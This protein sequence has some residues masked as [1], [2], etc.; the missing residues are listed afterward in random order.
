MM[1]LV[2]NNSNLGGNTGDIENEKKAFQ[3]NLLVLAGFMGIT[4]L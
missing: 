2:F 1:F 4:L 3:E